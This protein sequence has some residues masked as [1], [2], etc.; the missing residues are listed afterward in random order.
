M[1]CILLLS[2]KDGSSWSPLSSEPQGG[3]SLLGHSSPG[4][5]GRWALGLWGTQRKGLRGEFLEEIHPELGPGEVCAGEKGMEEEK[6]FPAGET[7]CTLSREWETPSQRL[8]HLMW[9]R[10]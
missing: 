9:T 4:P 2:N 1:D 7:S 6:V 10:A 8:S 5:D 3:V